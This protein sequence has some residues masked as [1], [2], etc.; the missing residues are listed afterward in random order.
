MIEK[1]ATLRWMGFVSGLLDLNHTRIIKF[2]SVLSDREIR[3]E[4][5][6]D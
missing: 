6:T 1:S 2:A 5:A 3:S 4:Q